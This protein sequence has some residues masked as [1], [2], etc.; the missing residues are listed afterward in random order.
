MKFFSAAIADDTDRFE[1]KFN[2]VPTDNNFRYKLI[3][4]AL[5]EYAY[6]METY[7]SEWLKNYDNRPKFEGAKLK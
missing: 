5:K 1:L 4:N 6:L 2:G 3:A 7:G